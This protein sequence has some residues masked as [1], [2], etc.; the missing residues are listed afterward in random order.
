MPCCA[1]V[2]VGTWPRTRSRPTDTC[3][4]RR[5]GERGRTTT[6]AAGSCVG[7]ARHPHPPLAVS[8]WCHST[9]P[10]APER[11]YYGVMDDEKRITL[12]LPADLHAWLATQAKSA[13]RS[14]NSEIVHRLEVE[15]TAEA[16]AGSP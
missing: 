10:C 5:A 3:P 15:R 12:R 4:T 2:P 6:R 11:H 8:I 16:D 1:D 13:H 7:H 14:L 9:T